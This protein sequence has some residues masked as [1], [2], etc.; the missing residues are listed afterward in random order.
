MAAA[1]V[2]V[3]WAQS[4]HA[5]TAIARD[6]VV[7]KMVPPIGL[8]ACVQVRRNADKRMSN[9]VCSVMM[10]QVCSMVAYLA[11]AAIAAMVSD[12]VFDQVSDQ[13]C[14][15][16]MAKALDAIESEVIPQI[17]AAGRDGVDTSTTGETRC[18]AAFTAGYH[19]PGSTR[20][21]A[22]NATLREVWSRT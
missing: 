16:V 13:V 19:A 11:S 7:G 17:N 4:R 8:A 14:I 20:H 3:T 21:G 2:V 12:Q 9:A 18:A 5:V 1:M 22:R 10:V 15:A 6:W